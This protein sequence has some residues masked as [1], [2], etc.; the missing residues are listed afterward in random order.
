MFHHIFKK[1][2]KEKAH[3]ALTQQRNS[4]TDLTSSR[5][6]RLSRQRNPLQ[7][8]QRHRNTAAR[9][10]TGLCHDP[11]LGNNR[12]LPQDTGALLPPHTGAAAQ[13]EASSTPK[14]TSRQREYVF[15]SSEGTDTT[16]ERGEGFF[17]PAGTQS[18]HVPHCSM[19]SAIAMH[20]Q[21]I[22]EHCSFKRGRFS[23]RVLKD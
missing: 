16:R 18:T 3:V 13:T 2:A 21:I 9:P 22:Q 8:G 1:T 20:R 12:H 7:T 17:H 23:P 19:S 4:E 10:R 5:R 6:Y 14:S 15:K 11:G